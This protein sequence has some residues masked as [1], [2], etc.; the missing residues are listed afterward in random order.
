MILSDNNNFK[1]L[2][3]FEGTEFHNSKENIDNS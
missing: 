1:G 2:S 3:S